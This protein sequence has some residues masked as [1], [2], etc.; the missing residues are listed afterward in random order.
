MI[1][2][3]TRMVSKNS[4]NQRDVTDVDDG[5]GG[6]RRQGQRGEQCSG[7]ALGP[8]AP[9]EAV[10]AETRMVD[11]PAS[12]GRSTEIWLGRQASVDGRTVPRLAILNPLAR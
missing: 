5:F 1:R 3:L 9:G 10:P 8:C 12:G 2:P 11:G 7:V 6:P 4:T